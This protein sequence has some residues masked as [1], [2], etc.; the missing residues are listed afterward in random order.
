[1]ATLKAIKVNFGVFATTKQNTLSTNTDMML[2]GLF[3]GGA[4][5][6]TASSND[7]EMKVLCMHKVEIIE[8]IVAALECLA[9]VAKQLVSCFSSI[10]KE[11]DN[12]LN[13]EIKEI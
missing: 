9:T 4:I 7:D 10:T 8:G 1:M 12:N 3:D 13:K 6:A 5:A 2:A 11:K